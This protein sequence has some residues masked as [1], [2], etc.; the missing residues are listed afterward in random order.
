[1]AA[2]FNKVILVGRLTRDPVMRSTP[3]GAKVTEFG[4]AVSEP[5]RDRQTNEWK[6]TTCF[7]DVVAWNRWAEAIQ[8][9][10]KKGMPVLL[11]GKLQYDEWKNDKGENRSKLRI[12]A[13]KVA[14]LASFQRREDGAPAAP[15]V[16]QTVQT[17]GPADH[18][19]PPAADDEDLPF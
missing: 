4:L 10:Y 13:E 8:E 9:R 17:E 6:E 2:S 3:S 15:T 19:P 5:Y 7:V 18:L 11:E 1:M 16:A 14:N 12:R